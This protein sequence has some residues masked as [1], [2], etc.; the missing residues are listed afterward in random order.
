MCLWLMECWVQR[1]LEILIDFQGRGP[2]G[3][4]VRHEAHEVQIRSHVGGRDAYMSHSCAYEYDDH[5][6]PMPVH[7]LLMPRQ[8][9]RRFCRTSG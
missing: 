9:R 4:E 3:C 8:M 1:L 6:L 2:G 7:Q 5:V